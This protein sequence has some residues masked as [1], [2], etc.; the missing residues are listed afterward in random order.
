[1]QKA[2]LYVGFAVHDMCSFIDL[3]RSVMD[4]KPSPIRQKDKKRL[5]ALFLGWYFN[6]NGKYNKGN[7]LTTSDIWYKHNSESG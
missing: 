4:Y 2:T 5:Q 3:H 1:M 7:M 6:E